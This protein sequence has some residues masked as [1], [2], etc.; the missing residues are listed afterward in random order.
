MTLMAPEITYPPRIPSRLPPWINKRRSLSKETHITSEVIKSRGLHSVCHEAKCPNLAECYSRKTVTFL[1]MGEFCTRG[2]RFCHIKTRKTGA[3]LDPFEPQKIADAT[4]ELGLK[5]VVLTSVARD[6]LPDEGAGHFASCVKACRDISPQ[7]RVEVLTPDF[8]GQ[9][10]LIKKFSKDP[11]HIFNHN[12]ETVERLQSSVRHRAT[13]QTSLKTLSLAKALIPN[14]IIKSGIMLGLGETRS[15]LIQCFKDIYQRGGDILT[16]GQYLRPSKKHLSVQKYYTLSEFDELKHLALK[17]G[18]RTV[19]S[20][21][22][23]RSSYMADTV[24]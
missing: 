4:Q 23:V 21:P 18:F 6:D 1:L 13:Y 9:S 24:I 20:G 10:T 19:F 22:Y 16:L 17:V 3:P 12:L 11:P 15:E 14:V 8:H 5:H 7:L 2:C